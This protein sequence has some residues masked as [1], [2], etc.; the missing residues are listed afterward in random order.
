MN[1]DL[2]LKSYSKASA[3]KTLFADFFFKQLLQNFKET[4]L[5]FK[6]KNIENVKNEFTRAVDFTIDHL[7]EPEILNI[8][9]TQKGK[10]LEQNGVQGF[11]YAFF[12]KT[13]IDTLAFF[14]KQDWNT[15]L[16]R[17]WVLTYENLVDI[18]N[19]SWDQN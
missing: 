18:M 17:E 1:T 15:D 9:L 4:S 16:L 2:I 6:D 13:L 7:N 11:H 14:L 5:L 3:N 12:G 8:F 10:F 19:S